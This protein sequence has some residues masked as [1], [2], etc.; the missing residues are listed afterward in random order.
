V[1]RR[2]KLPDLHEGDPTQ[3]GDDEL[4]TL[5]ADSLDNEVLGDVKV[6]GKALTG[7]ARWQRRRRVLEAE[8]E[9]R[10]FLA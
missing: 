4:P 6:G 1:Y 7:A 3:F 2:P 9:R 10:G 8:M 5:Y